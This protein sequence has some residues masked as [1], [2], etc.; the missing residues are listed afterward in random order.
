VIIME[1]K[2]QY[3]AGDILTSC[4]NVL[5]V[6]D[7]LLGHSA[8]VINQTQMIEAVINKPHIQIAK[9]STFLRHHPKHAV[10]RP[11]NKVWGEGAAG[12]AKAY[13][14]RKNYYKRRGQEKPPFSFSPN[15]P[16]DDPFA[17]VYCS[18]LVWLCYHFG[19]DH[20]FPNDGFLF[21]PEDL[22]TLLRKDPNFI[23]LYRHRNFKFIIDT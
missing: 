2:I 10:Y 11:K 14:A 12:F 21:S 1:R 16:L 23:T 4:D 7:G 17:S 20:S 5:N 8:I 13:L 18:K 22:D 3:R 6:P 19:A 15:E 9:I